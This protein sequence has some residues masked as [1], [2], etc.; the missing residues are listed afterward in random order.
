MAGAASQTHARASAPARRLVA[1]ATGAAVFAVLLIGGGG[2]AP[3]AA[4][5][6]GACSQPRGLRPSPSGPPRVTM[7]I[8]VNTQGDVDTYTKAEGGGGG[9]VRP[10]GIFC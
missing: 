6:Q 4:E 9:R 8:R 2:G 1:L 7:L 5:A 10:P 3:T